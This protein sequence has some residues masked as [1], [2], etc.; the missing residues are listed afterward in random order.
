VVGAGKE[1]PED[2]SPQRMAAKREAMI[3]E[4]ERR[5][6]AISK[7]RR[8]AESAFE[9]DSQPY[10]DAISEQSRA[11]D[12]DVQK[13]GELDMANTLREKFPGPGS[14]ARVAQLEKEYAQ[15][16]AARAAAD[17]HATALIPSWQKAQTNFNSASDQAN[18]DYEEMNAELRAKYV[19]APGSAAD[20]SQVSFNPARILGPRDASGHRHYQTVAPQS[21]ADGVKAV[22]QII[23]QGAVTD[24]FSPTINQRT[25]VPGGRAYHSTGYSPQV[26]GSITTGKNP[27][28]STIVH[29]MGHAVEDGINGASEAIWQHIDSRTQGET[30][31]SLRKLTGGGYRTDE[32]AKPDQFANP[33]MGK[34]NYGRSAS[35]FLSM[36]LQYMYQDPVGFAKKDPQS[37]D[38]AS[39]LLA[40]ARSN[41]GTIPLP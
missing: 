31:Q 11:L 2:F 20:L 25:N 27:P 21:Y 41:N 13:S 32:V 34:T 26:G 22:S 12:A 39:G 16:Q 19:N 28:T 17:Q 33:Y 5:T 15:T 8:D 40:Q 29:E 18:K 36:S 24:K 1:L 7:Q 9:R 38:F 6:A 10:M 23:G 14:D 30:P 4:S 35:E 3:A 37:F